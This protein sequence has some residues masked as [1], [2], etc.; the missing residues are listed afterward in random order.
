MDVT[1]LAQAP[2][3]SAHIPAMR[4]VLA[5]DMETT[6]DRVNIKATTTERMG[7]IGR[8]EGV[9]VHA[10]ALLKEERGK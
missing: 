3:L 10:V 7:F 9:A 5:E 8:R 2:K 1:I 4:K 6:T